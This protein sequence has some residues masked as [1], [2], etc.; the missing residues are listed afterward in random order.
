MLKGLQRA[1]CG[2]I[3]LVVLSGLGS[4]RTH[5]VGV[6]CGG[7]QDGAEDV[8]ST[9]QYIPVYIEHSMKLIVCASE[10]RGDQA[11][12]LRPQL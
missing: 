8:I 10:R 9:K 7:R 6:D 1:L 5:P 4:R 3:R 11:A 12:P 2:D